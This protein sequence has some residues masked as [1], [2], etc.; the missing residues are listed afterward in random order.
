MLGISRRRP[1]GAH[2]FAVFECPHVV[3]GHWA[4]GRKALGA[5]LEPI[6]TVTGAGPGGDEAVFPRQHLESEFGSALAARS[7]L[8]SKSYFWGVHRALL[9]SNSDGWGM[10]LPPYN[11]DGLVLDSGEKVGLGRKHGRGMSEMRQF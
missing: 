7:L 6:T 5:V 3:C 2:S 8:G 4:G 9:R 11:G 1:G 10:A